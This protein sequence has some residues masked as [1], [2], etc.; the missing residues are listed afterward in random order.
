M[1]LLYLYLLLFGKQENSP[2]DFRNEYENY[3]SSRHAK[4]HQVGE[5]IKINFFFTWALD[6]RE[7]LASRPRLFT[8]YEESMVPTQ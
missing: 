1:G 8:L 2:F 7:C 6:G 3:P 4:S 5:K